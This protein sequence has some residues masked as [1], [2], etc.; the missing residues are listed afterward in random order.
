MAD[1]NITS[2]PPAT[3]AGLAVSATRNPIVFVLESNPIGSPVNAYGLLQVTGTVSAGDTIV[4][5]GSTYTASDDPQENGAEFISG[6]AS[7]FL[8]VAQS[9]KA[10][11][12]GDPSLY[13]YHFEV[14]GVIFPT[15]YI[16]AT[17]PGTQYNVTLSTTGGAIT[18]LGTSPG[19]DQYRGQSLE[20]YK[21]WAKLY[22]NSAWGFAQY[23]NAQPPF[24]T[25]NKLRGFFDMAYLQN[26]M[27]VDVSLLLDGATS[28]TPPSLSAGFQSMQS[29]TVAY[30]IEYGEEFIPSGSTNPIQRVVGRSKVGYGLNSAI[31]T[32]DQNDMR[33][34]VSRQPLQKFLTSEPLSRYIRGN[35]RSWLSFLWHEPT[36]AVRWI[37]VRV[38]A[39]F[40]DGTSSTVGDF[41]SMQAAPGYNAIRIDP[42]SW[43]M[44][45]YETTNGK[46]VER[47]QVYLVESANPTMTA[48]YKLTELREFVIDRQCPGDGAI[49]FV[50]LDPIGGW[51][52]FTLYGELV[53]EARRTVSTFRRSRRIAGWAATDVMDAVS[54]I[55]ETIAN[56]SSSGDVD[57]ITFRWLRESMLRSTMVYV[58]G[59]SSLFPV[60]I[61]SHEAKSGTNDLTYS[62]SVTW[63]LSAPMNSMRG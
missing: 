12:E 53:T 59:G 30:F 41:H 62:L 39:T 48:S 25:T 60:V 3:T 38:I 9:I 51:C 34:Y 11:L 32:L 22:T 13:A 33:Q 56:T 50:W 28:H 57:A 26:S 45:G 2:Q 43:N 58:V 15:I 37:A 55:S 20:S 27:P 4:L 7:T 52:G 63:R 18:V 31:G 1:L 19:Q 5:N 16:L 54:E 8:Q 40:Y 17:N 49:R 44:A 46:L 10:V 14:Q 35:D 21:A 24:S 61:E 23:L 29:P 42:E 6:A 36:N 47:Y